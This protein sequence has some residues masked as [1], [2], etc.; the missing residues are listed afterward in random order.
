MRGLG[1]VGAAAA[2]AVAAASA[3]AQA[4]PT[5]VLR[6]VF[7]AAET[8][9]D[10]Q[11]SSDVYSNHVIRAIFDGPY[12]YDH[13]ARPYRIVPNTAVA[14]PEI[15]ADGLAWTIRIK[16]GTPSRTTRRSSGAGH[17]ADSAGGYRP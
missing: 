1:R 9:F 11:A 7:P 4:D 6:V 8:G 2:F 12:R 10:P 3:F 16:P 5:K 15:S 17:T 14:L 13:L